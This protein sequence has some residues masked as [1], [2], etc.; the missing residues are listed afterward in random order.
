MVMC[1][2]RYGVLQWMQKVLSEILLICESL[3]GLQGGMKSA[4]CVYFCGRET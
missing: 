3:S 2:Q 4:V 1:D